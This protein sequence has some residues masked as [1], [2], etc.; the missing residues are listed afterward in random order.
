VARLRLS[1]GTPAVAPKASGVR[2]L[3]A[4]ALEIIAKVGGDA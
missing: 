3:P 1:G 2:T 4:E